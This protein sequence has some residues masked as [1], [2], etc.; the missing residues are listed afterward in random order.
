MGREMNRV[1]ERIGR[2]F[3]RF[4]TEWGNWFDRTFGVLRPLLGALFGLVLLIIVIAIARRLS[5]FNIGAF[6][7]SYLLVFFVLMVA[8]GYSAY[9]QRKYR[10]ETRWLM[11][12]TVAIGLAISFWILSEL[13][14]ALWHDTGLPGLDVVGLLF[15]VL[16]IVILVLVIVIGYVFM[17]VVIP[18][19]H[20]NS[21][22]PPGMN[23]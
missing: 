6:L 22:S 7:L 5:L 10:K 21:Q 12:V 14:Y 23:G 17:C 3:E 11:P 4:G 18:R 1:G 19:E 16:V 2:D 9:A 13:S 20:G 15:R 8:F